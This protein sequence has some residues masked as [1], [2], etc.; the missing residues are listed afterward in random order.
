M[1]VEKIAN[2]VIEV[3]GK[4]VNG[5][6]VIPVYEDGKVVRV[7]KEKELF[8][9]TY[10]GYGFKMSFLGDSQDKLAVYFNDQLVYNS[11]GSAYCPS[12]HDR[13]SPTL[14]LLI[15]EKERVDKDV[16]SST[17]D[18]YIRGDWEDLLL[19]LSQ[20]AEKIKEKNKQ[21][22]EETEK[23][24]LHKKELNE[25]MLKHLPFKT[26]F[27][28]SKRYKDSMIVVEGGEAL[29]V[30]SGGAVVFDY[31]SGLYKPG[32]WEDR[33]KRLVE[34]DIKKISKEAAKYGYDPVSLRSLKEIEQEKREEELR[35]M[36]KKKRYTNA[37]EYLKK[38][39]NFI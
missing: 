4:K 26:S 20:N 28:G 1:N 8:E 23:I 22:A 15:P 14:I 17:P 10:D 5:H 32:D 19:F 27:D 39:K 21:L 12:Q 35:N 6:R 33:V 24:N 29:K 11:V 38:L 25:S 2:G 34:E 7:D 31:V 36:P 30:Y 18:T 16:R 3:L 9:R 37:E 13:I